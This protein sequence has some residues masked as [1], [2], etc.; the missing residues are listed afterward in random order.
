[1]GKVDPLLGFA[2]LQTFV[3]VLQEYFGDVSMITVKENFDIVY[4]VSQSLCS[5]FPPGN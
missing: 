5:L 1:M 2:F 3:D 4:Q